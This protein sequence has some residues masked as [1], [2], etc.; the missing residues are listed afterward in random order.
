[1]ASVHQAA[2]KRKAVKKPKFKGKYPGPDKFK[3]NKKKLAKYYADKKKKKVVAKK[4]AAKKPAA[5]PAA[6]PKPVSPNLPNTG[7]GSGVGVDSNGNLL[8]QTNFD[9]EKEIIDAQQEQQQANEQA[10]ALNS[11]ALISGS[12]NRR[13]ALNSNIDARTR[14]AGRMA[15]RGMRGTAAVAADAEISNAHTENIS[16]INIR[17]KQG[18]DTAANMITAAATRKAQRDAMIATARKNYT[19]EQSKQN[20][21]AGSKPVNSGV[22]PTKATP[23]ATR[24]AAKKAVAAKP[25]PK[26]FKGKYPGPDKFK[27]KKPYK[28]KRPG[29]G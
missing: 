17:Q 21:T 8:L 4:P 16:N 11:E 6:A 13:S 5:K 20:P 23:V 7:T 2:A 26:A 15:A 27:G 29:P 3:G 25:K 28:G 10:A 9:I 12:E 14:S 1:M 24:P 22:T 18:T 19:D